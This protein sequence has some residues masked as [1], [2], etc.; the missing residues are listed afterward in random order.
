M[1]QTESE[2]QVD[3]EWI[4]DQDQEEFLIVELMGVGDNFGSRQD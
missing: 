1:D 2:L 4:F 3:G